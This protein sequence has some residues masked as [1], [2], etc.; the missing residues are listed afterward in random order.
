MRFLRAY[1][2]LPVPKNDSE[3]RLRNT[4]QIALQAQFDNLKMDVFLSGGSSLRTWMAEMVNA[5]VSLEWDWLKQ[6]AALAAGRASCSASPLARERIVEDL[7]NFQLLPS[8]ANDADL[9]ALRSDFD[10]MMVGWACYR[11]LPQHVLR[12]FDGPRFSTL[13]RVTAR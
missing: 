13:R 9:R 5:R 12:F 2:S 11:R 7:C 4:A 3:L 6:F 10:L 8:P 1:T